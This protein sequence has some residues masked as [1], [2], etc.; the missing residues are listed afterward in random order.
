[1]K[2]TFT[3]L[4]SVIAGVGAVIGIQAQSIDLV[5]GINYSY[6]P[7][8]NDCNITAIEV[9]ACNNDNDAASAF[10]VGMYL[11]ETSSG[12]YWVID[13]FR[14]NSGLSGNAC[15]TISNWDINIDNSGQSIPN[16]TYRLGVWVDASQEITET[17]ESNNAGLLS[18]NNTYATCLNGIRVNEADKYF[19]VFP[20]PA[21]SDLFIKMISTNETASIKILDLSGKLVKTIPGSAVAGNHILQADVSGLENGFYFIQMESGDKS[22]RKKFVIQ[23]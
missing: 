1:M 21:S 3:K 15:V 11:Y 18:G 14:L 22:I 19:S 16:G 5:P 20:V 9:D 7:A 6:N 8:N 12:N 2:T 17:D 23:R 13:K 4:A 10:D